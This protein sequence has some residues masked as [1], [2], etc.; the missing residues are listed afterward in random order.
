MCR[1]AYIGLRWDV[2]GRM[3]FVS[4]DALPRIDPFMGFEL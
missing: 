2:I 1:T 4:L 3:I